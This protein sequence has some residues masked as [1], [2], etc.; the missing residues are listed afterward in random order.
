MFCLKLG[1]LGKLGKEII[2]CFEIS[3]VYMSLEIVAREIK[4]SRCT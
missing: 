4:G 3:R 2:E 1:K